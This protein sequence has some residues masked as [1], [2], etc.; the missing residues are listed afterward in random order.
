ME[1]RMPEARFPKTLYLRPAA[2]GYERQR[3]IVVHDRLCEVASL[4]TDREVGV[5]ELVRVATVVTDVRLKD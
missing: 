2:A 3:P 5:Y 1:D 4:E